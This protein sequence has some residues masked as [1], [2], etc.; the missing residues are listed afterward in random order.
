MVRSILSMLFFWILAIT[1]AF[2]E[3]G[4]KNASFWVIMGVYRGNSVCI[5]FPLIRVANNR[6]HINQIYKTNE[7]RVEND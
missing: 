3:I 5:L 2:N 6:S 4:I 1:L 7:L